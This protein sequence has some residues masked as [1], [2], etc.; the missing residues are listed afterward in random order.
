MSCLMLLVLISQ[1][2]T[3]LLVYE[4]TVVFSNSSHQLS[5]GI[6]ESPQQFLRILS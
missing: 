1:Y 2:G 3:V 4:C 6:R 5:Y